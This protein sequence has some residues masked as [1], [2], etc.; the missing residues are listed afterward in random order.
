MMQ[1]ARKHDPCI[2]FIS[3]AQENPGQKNLIKKVRQCYD[4]PLF[5]FLDNP[6]DCEYST[7]QD[8]CLTSYGL[9]RRQLLA[10]IKIIFGKAQAQGKLPF[11]IK[12]A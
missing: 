8:T 4:N 2:L 6:F 12:D 3:N 5:V 9:R 11:R 7:P 10:L 1:S